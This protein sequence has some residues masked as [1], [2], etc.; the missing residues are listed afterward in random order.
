MPVSRGASDARGP[1]YRLVG[2]FHIIM[3]A[4]GDGC[5]VSEI[6]DNGLGSGY[7]FVCHLSMRY[8]NPANLIHNV[9]NHLQQYT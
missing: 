5:D 1:F 2:H 8:D 7:E 3:P 4:N 6:A 9:I